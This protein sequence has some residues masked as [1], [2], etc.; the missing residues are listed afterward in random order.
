MFLW[1]LAT[2]VLPLNKTLVEKMGGRDALCVLCGLEDDSSSNLFTKCHVS[3][4]LAFASRLSVRLETL[5][6]SSSVA[7]VRM[8]LSLRDVSYLVWKLLVVSYYL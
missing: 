3:S 1:R 6:S 4:A 7:M 5:C 2:N 8:I